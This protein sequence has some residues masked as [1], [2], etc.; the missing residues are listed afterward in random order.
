[1]KDVFK[2]ITVKD[3]QGKEVVYPF[4][5]NTNVSETMQERYGSLT[6]WADKLQ[7][8]DTVDEKSGETIKGEPRIKDIIEMYMECINEGIDMEN[9]DKGE[10]RQFLTHKQVGRIVN[11]IKD[12][13]S[14]LTDLIRESND[15]GTIKNVQTEPM[16]TP[17]AE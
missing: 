16:M 3:T 17:T 8:P 9:E 15:D 7:P 1:M 12:S 5:F 10:K 6:K 11:A 14:Q 2:H 4:V 13:Q